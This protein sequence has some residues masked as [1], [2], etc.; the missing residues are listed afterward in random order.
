MMRSKSNLLAV[1]AGVVALAIAGWQLVVFSQHQALFV[2]FRAFY[3]GGH[4]LLQHANPYTA[5]A[6][7]GC[8]QRPEPFGLYAVAVPL[9]APFAGYQLG[10]FALLAL[11][12]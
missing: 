10:A 3:C 8:E 11:L 9:V 7:L 2:D 6:L 5:S 12:P 4:A 1:A